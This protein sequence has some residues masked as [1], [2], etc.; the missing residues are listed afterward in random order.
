MLTNQIWLL[1]SLTYDR[2]QLPT[3]LS[4]KTSFGFQ[5]KTKTKKP[6]SVRYLAPMKDDVLGWLFVLSN[7]ACAS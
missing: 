2:I 1:A 6:Q 5:L 7:P 4:S 3:Y